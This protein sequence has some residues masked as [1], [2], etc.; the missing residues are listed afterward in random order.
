MLIKQQIRMQG[1][2]RD[3][4]VTSSGLLNGTLISINTLLTF[5]YHLSNFGYVQ[6]RW[7]I[8]WIWRCEQCHKES[9]HHMPELNS[10]QMFSGLACLMQVVCNCIQC[11]N[12]QGCPRMCRLTPGDCTLNVILMLDLCSAVYPDEPSSCLLAISVTELSYLQTLLS[13]VHSS[14]S[15]L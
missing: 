7:F 9:G 5:H 13:L 2:E 10:S 6:I 8:L 3:T 11:V 12:L 14:L 4:R 15:L 1:V